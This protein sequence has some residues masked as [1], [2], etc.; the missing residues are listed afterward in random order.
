MGAA[1]QP[2]V[3]LNGTEV[4]KAQPQGVFFEDVIPGDY[5]IVTATE[6]TRKLSLKVENGQ[7]RYVRLNISM[8]FM[9]G[10]VYPELV[11]ESVGAK[12]ILDCHF[13]GKTK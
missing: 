13:V 3:H 12:E 4:G 6:V 1:I 10:H 7:T 2:A 9:V 8:G 5:E 11:D